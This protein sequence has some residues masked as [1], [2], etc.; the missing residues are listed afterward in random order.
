MLCVR[1]RVSCFRVFSVLFVM[2]ACVCVFGVCVSLCLWCDC[3]WCCCVLSVLLFRTH[4]GSI[5]VLMGRLAL[6]L[7]CTFV[8]LFMSSVVLCVIVWGRGVLLCVCV[9]LCVACLCVLLLPLLLWYV[10]VCVFMVCVFS[11]FVM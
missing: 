1:L 4:G 3:V 2:G 9:C 5:T 6:R 7:H 11:L 8:C 10:C